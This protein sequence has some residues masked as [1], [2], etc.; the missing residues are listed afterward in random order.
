MTLGGL[1][2]HLAYVEDDWFSQWLH[3]A[4]RQLPWDTVDW[5]TDPDWDWYSAAED[6]LKQL[7]TLWQDAVTRSRSLVTRDLAAG[8]VGEPLHPAVGCSRFALMIQGVVGGHRF[9]VWVRRSSVRLSPWRR[10]KSPAALVIAIVGAGGVSS[11]P[12]S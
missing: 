10:P 4:D 2:K 11:C 7:L 6:T 12:A 5:H 9:L 1:L 8:S 3:G